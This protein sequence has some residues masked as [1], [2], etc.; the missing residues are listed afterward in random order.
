MT[1]DQTFLF[2]LKREVDKADALHLASLRT[3]E[4]LAEQAIHEWCTDQD[5]AAATMKAI[6]AWSQQMQNALKTRT[7]LLALP[8]G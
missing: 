4:K 2:A 7:E 5:S 1:T 6:V 3:A 8:P